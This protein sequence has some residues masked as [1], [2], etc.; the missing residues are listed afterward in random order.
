MWEECLGKGSPEWERRN[1]IFGVGMLEG[2]VCEG[3]LGMDL[4]CFWKCAA[5]SG[6][7][8]MIDR[9]AIWAD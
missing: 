2:V 6:N 8:E 4:N 3:C 7:S 9:T 5:E 1:E